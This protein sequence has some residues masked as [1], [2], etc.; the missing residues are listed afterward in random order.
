MNRAAGQHFHVDGRR[1]GLNGPDDDPRFARV[2]AEDG[3]RKPV[4]RLV[5]VKM[6]MTRPRGVNRNLESYEALRKILRVALAYERAT[7]WH[8][9][10]PEVEQKL[11]E[12][13]S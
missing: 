11:K 3:E 10:N 7:N 6:P 12:G 13:K 5:L 2:R 4:E 1:G 9:M 8:G